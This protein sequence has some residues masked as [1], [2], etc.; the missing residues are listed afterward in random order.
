MSLPAIFL[1]RARIRGMK[2][3]LIQSGR[4]EATEF[5]SKDGVERPQDY[6]FAANVVDG[7]GLVITVDGTTIIL[8]ADK[9]AD[10]PQLAAHEV[11]VWHKEG[12]KITMRDGK[13]IDVECDTLR[14]AATTK[15]QFITPLVTISAKATVGDTLAVTNGLTGGGNATF[16]NGRV[17]ALGITGNGK[18]LETHT[19]PETGGVTLPN[20]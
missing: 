14:V 2:E 13:L 16:A 5:D 4:M 12:H 3:G 9:I 10:R 8:R 18:V 15:I 19:H 11:T 7:Q 17:S 6:G 1:R 20:T